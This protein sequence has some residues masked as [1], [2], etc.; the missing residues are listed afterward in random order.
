[1]TT[2]FDATPLRTAPA[3][4]PTLPTGTYELPISAPSTAQQGCLVNSAQADAWSCN[5]PMTS[6]TI[7]LTGIPGASDVDDNEVD[8]SLGNNTFPGWYAYGSQPPLLPTTQVL[9]LVTD[10]QDPS[11]GPAWFFELPYDKLVILPENAF[12]S[13]SSKRDIEYRDSDHSQPPLSRDDVA[14]TNDKPWFCYWNG[15]LLEAFIYVSN[16]H[17]NMKLFTNNQRRSI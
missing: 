1:M 3:G 16:N 13:S 11:R 17:S 6:Y 10:S 9:N 7:T 4:L 15:T 14:Q 12:T 8:F 2:T 5:I